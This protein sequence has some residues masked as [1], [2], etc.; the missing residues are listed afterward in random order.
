MP[1]QCV[2]MAWRAV[3]HR[4]RAPRGS[5]KESLVQYNVWESCQ[6]PIDRILPTPYRSSD[7]EG[8][9]EYALYTLS[10]T[11]P[12]MRALH[13]WHRT[14]ASHTVTARLHHNDRTTTRRL[15]LESAMRRLTNTH[16]E[17]STAQV[18]L[19][20]GTQC[21]SVVAGLNS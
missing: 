3:L 2:P 7:A 20:G 5:H 8:Q 21:C 15:S 6:V 18:R 14:T 11:A 4:S 12:Q 16:R 13:Q 19:H 9:G 1:F 17:L 10:P